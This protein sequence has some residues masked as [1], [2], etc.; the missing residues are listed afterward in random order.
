M[1]LRLRTEF[2]LG[3]EGR[4]D[5]DGI[6]TETT[7]FKFGLERRDTISS[8]QA[9]GTKQR[10]DRWAEQLSSR[11]GQLA[12]SDM[13]RISYEAAQG[14]QGCFARV[15]LTAWPTATDALD[16]RQWWERVARYYGMPSPACQPHVGKPL[17]WRR[18]SGAI[19]TGRVLDPYGGALETGV[20][21]GDHWRKKH[22]RVKYAIATAALA[23]GAEV[24]V[25]VFNLFADL[26]SASDMQ[27]LQTDGT[28]HMQGMVPDFRFLGLRAPIKTFLAELKGITLSPTHYPVQ[29]ATHTR[30]GTEP[31]EHR[32]AAIQSEYVRK[33]R[34][35]D[36]RYRNDHQVEQRLQ[37]FGAILPLVFGPFNEV[38]SRFNTLVDAMATHGATSLWRSMLAKDAAM[39]KG[40][41][42]NRMRRSIGMAMHRAN[43]DL[44]LNRVSLVGPHAEGAANRRAQ[45]EA[46]WWGPA[47]PASVHHDSAASR[48]YHGWG[49]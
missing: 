27:N 23:A 6:L 48:R 30:I 7:F 9:R 2:G 18:R 10:E 24:T 43:A 34:A 29:G 25:E 38:N 3:G 45:T 44:I 41:L 12:R 15:L 31:C 26:F 11:I 28:R 32:A 16:P 33:A 1:L 13:R 35:L 19:V 8:T 20:L 39:A 47:G 21:P 5:Q 36:T 49:H 46:R 42:L 17:R 22:D 40:P 37:S 4:G 14:P